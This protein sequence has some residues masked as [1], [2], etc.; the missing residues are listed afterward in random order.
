MKPSALSRDLSIDTLAIHAG[1]PPDP[2]SGAVM[3]PI[4]LAST[5]AQASPLVSR[6][7]PPYLYTP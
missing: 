7:P 3:M 1:Q 6:Q 2:T 5:F 4:V